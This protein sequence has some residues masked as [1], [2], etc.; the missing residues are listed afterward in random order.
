M[1]SSIT[2]QAGEVNTTAPTAGD[3]C[4]TLRG[5]GTLYSD[6]SNCWLQE[7]KVFGRLQYQ[8]AY[9]DG[10]VNGNR[11]FNYKT[12]EFRRVYLGASAKVFNHL[13]LSG[14]ANVFDDQGP[15]GGQ[16]GF[17]FRHMW[18]LY[19][20]L[21]L[22][23][24]FG[25]RG[26]DA[27]A[28]GYGAREVNMSN[29]FNHS[30][31]NIKTVERSAISNKIWAYDS[32]FSNPT[33]AWLE[34]KNGNLA[35]TFGAFSTTQ[36]DWLASW[37]DGE[38]YHA[39][40]S[41]DFSGATGADISRVLWTHFYQDLDANDE[42]LADGLE[43]ATSLSVNYGNGPWELVVEGV[44]GDNGEQS[45][46]AREGDFWAVV[47]MPTYWLQKDKLEAVFRYQYEGSEEDQG[48]RVYS[49]YSRRADAKENLGM[50]NGGRGDEHHSTYAGLNYY[51]CGNNSK[52]MAGVQYDTITSGG[53]DVYDGWTSMLAFRT[54]F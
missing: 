16:E 32:E 50:L 36:D 37:E 8:L 29:E 42:R 45:N 27:L 20:L 46:A 26:F 38:L 33:G 22:K 10:E 52:V 28:V 2:G 23:G 1:G 41:Y 5:I 15:V 48:V 14:Q 25:I 9:V 18:D 34:G 31:K 53:D 13:K 17:E 44:Y 4:E 39:N 7:F 12:D 30:S 24:A 40:L 35:W 21:D 47:V 51:F 49:R 11:D 43:W 6:D 3:W 54:F 19:G